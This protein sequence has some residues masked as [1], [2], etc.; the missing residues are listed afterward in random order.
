M[1]KRLLLVVFIFFTAYLSLV[2]VVHAA[3]REFAKE[4]VLSGLTVP[5]AIQFGP[6]GQLFIAEKYGEIKVFRN[7]QLS[8]FASLDVNGDFE[9][10]LLSIVLDPNFSTNRYLYV[11]YTVPDG[12]TN[13]VSRIT[14][15]AT[16]YDVMEPNSEKILIEN[17]PSPTGIH[18]LGELQIGTDG[19]LYI[20]AGD[21]SISAETSQ[22]L[23]NLNGKMLRLNLDGT[24]P[25]D[26]PFYGQAGKRGEIWAYGLR[27]PFTSAKHPVNGRIF[28]NDVGRDDWEEINELQRGANY[29]WTTCEG[30]CNPSR[31][32]FTDPFYQYNH[33]SG[34]V[35]GRAVT[36]GAWYTGNIYPEDFVDDYFFSDYVGGWIKKIDYQT[37]EVVDIADGMSG[38]INLK[39]G[40]DGLLYFVRLD[41]SSGMGTVGKLT[42]TDHNTGNENS[43]VIKI[44]AAGSPA[45][46]VYPTAEL[47]VDDFTV[48]TFTNI[49]GSPNNRQFNE[50]SHTFPAVITPERIKIKFTNDAYIGNQDRNLYVDKISLDNTEYQTEDQ[51]VYSVGTWTPDTGCNGGHKRSEALSC[52]G[53]FQYGAVAASINQKP[54]PDI[55][56]PVAESFYSGGDIINFSGSAQDPEDGQLSATNLEWTVVFHHDTHTH[57]F[58]TFSN[59]AFGSFQIPAVG[60]TAA[61]VFF[62]I[63]LK[64][65]DSEGQTQ[66]V[67]RDVFPRTSQL[68]LETSPPSLSVNLDGQSHASPYSFSGV[69]GVERLLSAVQNQTLNHENYEFVS[70]SDG[71]TQSHKFT[72]PTA[73]TIYTA[74]YR[75]VA[76]P[77]AADSTQIKLWAAGTPAAGGYPT[78]ELLIDDV[79]A[80]TFTD[81]RGNVNGRQFTEYSHTAVGS[82]SAERIKL[83]F[84]NDLYINNEDRNLHIDKISLNGTVFETED[85]Q[86]YSTG[87]WSPDSGCAPG[88]KKSEAL[89]CA[90]YF[91][92]RLPAQPPSTGSSLTIF[93]AGTPAQGIYPNLEILV[94]GILLKTFTSVQGNPQTRTFQELTIDSP[95]KINLSQLQLRFTNDAFINNEDR[96]LTVD[97]ISLDGVTYET[98]AD[99]VYSQ[100]AWNAASGCEP[101]SKKLETLSCNGYFAFGQ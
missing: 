88:N 29:G 34:P 8:T 37:K 1:L 97:K 100:G 53:Y 71:G 101:G 94:N 42:L 63:Q 15:S 66:T 3:H 84:A 52:N 77:L 85:Q 22:F 46:G 23:D 21:G 11:A 99:S 60:E 13:R 56:T 26:N 90:G 5:V 12:Y 59:Q 78:I 41:V 62:R 7:G 65:T 39:V 58:Q 18:E 89:M 57:P 69:V 87:T 27:N 68:K 28:F 43:T 83:R 48:A 92:Y 81:I 14:A 17:I 31:S 33:Y 20:A 55:S 79:I 2:G 19:K 24:I 9:Q 35:V 73:A 36:G 67:I 49:Q 38:I 91:H 54:V 95:S 4:I 30:K 80:A 51:T 32:E 64:A 86:V 98:E 70:W 82:V 50:L 16:N 74:Q 40:P 72:T 44:F 25:T 76:V 6:E 93:T 96:N 47:L 10:G 45:A 61:N 75:K